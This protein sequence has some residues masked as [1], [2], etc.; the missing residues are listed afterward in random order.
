MQLGMI[1]LGRMGGNMTVRLLRGGHQMIVW[2]R[3]KGPVE[4]AVAA[5]A[6]A[7]ADIPDLVSK[8]AAPRAA[9]IMR[10]AGVVT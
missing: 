6:T 2:N 8:L 9:W 10:P 1:G 5:G 4:E 3:S 7:A